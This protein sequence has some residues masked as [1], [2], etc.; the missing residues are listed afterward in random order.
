MKS[1]EA[2]MMSAK[3]RITPSVSSP[4]KPLPDV[5]K[6]PGEGRRVVESPLLVVRSKTKLRIVRLYENASL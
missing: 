2:A 5:G 1:G 6:D 3:S 4:R